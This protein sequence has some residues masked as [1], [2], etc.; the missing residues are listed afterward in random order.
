MGPKGRLRV[1]GALPRWHALRKENSPNVCRGKSPGAPD[2]DL[3]VNLVP[4][5]HRAGR[6]AELAA[7]FGGHRDLSLRGQA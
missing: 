4:F 1:H 3:P 2:D 5:K 6:E 7:D